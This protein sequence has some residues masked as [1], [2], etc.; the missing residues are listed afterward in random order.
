LLFPTAVGGD[1]PDLLFL[2]IIFL[3]FVFFV[4]WKSSPSSLFL[5]LNSPFLFQSRPQSVMEEALSGVGKFPTASISIIELCN[6][7]FHHTHPHCPIEQPHIIRLCETRA[8]GFL[9]QITQRITAGF[10]EI[11]NQI[12][13]LDVKEIHPSR[14]GRLRGGGTDENVAVVMP[15]E[16]LK[17][18]KIFFSPFNDDN[19][20]NNN[21]YDISNNHWIQLIQF[22]W[23]N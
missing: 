23:Y 11:W 7:V 4:L 2:K 6:M 1:L 14:A 20:N 5:V 3:F 9:T 18:I 13:T 17:T 22:S 19:N 10:S 8:E 21:S 12:Y 15:G 16:I